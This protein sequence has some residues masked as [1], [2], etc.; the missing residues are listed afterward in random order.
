VE[1]LMLIVLVTVLSFAGFAIVRRVP[2][3][4]PLFGFGPPARTAFRTAAA[5]PADPSP[6][7]A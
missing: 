4:R 1:A 7:G 3:L 5:A 2:G 6:A